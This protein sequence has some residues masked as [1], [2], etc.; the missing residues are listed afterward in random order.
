M[1]KGNPDSHSLTNRNSHYQPV[2]LELERS[3]NLPRSSRNDGAA[4]NDQQLRHRL[5]VSFWMLG[6]LNNASYVLMIACAKSMSEGG[7]GLIF[8]ANI[9]PSLA[10][11]LSAPYWFDGVSYYRRFQ[12]ATLC[13]MTSF[14]LVAS[15][16]MATPSNDDEHDNLVLVS[17]LVMLLIR[18]LQ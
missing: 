11:K 1:M 5:I 14:A 10:I 13:M 9:V 17:Q 18:Y 16:A 6:L 7:T 12:A 15:T 8:L 4:T 2:P 3:I